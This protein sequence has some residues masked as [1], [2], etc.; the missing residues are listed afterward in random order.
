MNDLSL[1]F[2]RH[3]KNT[4]PPVI[5]PRP[6]QYYELTVLIRGSLCYVLNGEPVHLRAGDAV[7][8]EK[9]TH[10]ERLATAEAADY[11]SF[12]FDTD[13]P[14]ALPT[15]IEGALSH[16]VQLML[17]A[18]DEINTADPSENAALTYLLQALILL[19]RQGLEANRLHPLTERI[20]AYLKANI[21]RRITLAD[22]GALTYFSPIYCDTV[23]KKDMGRSIIDYLLELRVNEAKSL[24][25]E[26][27]LGLK[28]IAEHT[29]FGD[30][31]YLSRIFKKRT[32]Y[33]PL[34]YR[35]H[36]LQ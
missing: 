6:I 27:E 19:L 28:E 13:T 10:R 22:I 23:F 12:N 14:P 11:F 35:K 34:Q 7:F 3:N 25:L 18:A 31:N 32:G 26:G 1:F 5:V 33:T 24:L 2:I 21:G 30:S 17:A 9:G 8:V 4:I 20:T 29:G 16:G 36:T 15:R